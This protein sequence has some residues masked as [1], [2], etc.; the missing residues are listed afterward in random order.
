MLAC[1]RQKRSVALKP[2]VGFVVPR[3]VDIDYIEARRFAGRYSDKSIGPSFPPCSDN[4]SVNG[5][6]FEAVRSEWPLVGLAAGEYEQAAFDEREPLA[7]LQ[8]QSD[9]AI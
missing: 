6:V 4:I 7:L 5:R 9:F 8:R 1:L 2:V 3:T